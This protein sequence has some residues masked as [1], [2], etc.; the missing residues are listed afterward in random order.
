MDYRGIL[1]IA[2]FLLTLLL[3]MKRPKRINLGIAAGIGAILSLVLGTVSLSDAAI[4]LSKIWDASLAFV[5][6]VT[7]SV[8]LDAMGFFKY[9]AL[10]VARLAK[11]N[12][13]KLYFYTALLTAMVSVL[14]ANDSAVLILTPIVMEMVTALALVGD[15]RLAYLFGAGLIADTAAMPLIT[16]NPVN[17]VSA[18]YFGYTFVQHFLF[19][20][21]VAVATI[22]LSLII[23]FLFFRKKIPRTFSADLVDRLIKETPEPM[24]L[25]TSVGTLVVIDIGYVIASYNGI[26]VS[27]VIC[28]G[29]LFLI[30]LYGITCKRI[31]DSTISNRGVKYVL[32]KLNWDILFFMIGIFLVVDGLQQAGAIDGFA[33]LFNS[34]LQLPGVLSTLVPCLIVTIAASFMNNWSMTMMGLLATNQAITT[35][36]LSPQASTSMIFS[37]VIG[38]N[39]GP[40]FFPLGSLAI[41]MWMG[42]MKR[43]GLTIKFKD[44]LKVGSILSIIEVT[45][46]AL[47]LWLEVGVFSMVLPSII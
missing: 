1:S 45:V 17:I 29:A 2:I 44:Y 18:D 28:A 36:H 27:F 8:T 3:I 23:V 43:K 34:G 19:M 22:F 13:V 40:H 11:G 5:G 7:L 33:S 9:T 26:P 47:I 32:K 39:L 41:L 31:V 30:I 14:F 6:I 37:N 16:S 20:G 38:N 21:P 46:A 15:S 24:W 12:G 25:R 35:Y 42:T 10:R 4:A